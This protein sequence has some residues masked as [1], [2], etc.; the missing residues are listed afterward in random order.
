LDAADAADLVFIDESVSSSRADA[1]IDTTT[2]VINNEQYAFDNWGM[3][4]VNVGHG[5]PQRPTDA[6]AD[7]DAGSS[8][9]T[10]IELVDAA[11]PI[12]VRAGLSGLVQ[13]YDDVGGR[14]DWGRPGLE[15]DVVAQLPGFEDYQ[16]ASPI[17][18]YEAGSRLD[19]G[20][21][22]PGM[23][24]GFFISDTNRGPEPEDPDLPD[25]SADNSWDGNEA[26][27]LTEAGIALFNATVDY[28]LGISANA[29]GDYN[30]DGMLDAED[31]DLQAAEM[32]KDLA[33]QD[34]LTFDHNSDGV[35]NVGM[36]GSDTSRWGDRL[37]WIRNLRQTSVGDSNLD[38]VFDSGDLVQAFTGEKYGTGE[39]AGWE[40]GDWNGDMVF[41]SGDLVF[42]FTDGGYVSGATP[43]AVPEP[44][45]LVLL[46]FG[47]FALVH[48]IRRR[49]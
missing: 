42:A 5:S 32:K 37:I 11:H 19:D 31:I 44:A 39:M 24:I 34:L 27:L 29:P 22:A 20:S 2:P 49:E 38:G 13:V 30:G 10:T 1:I 8:F 43:V 25:D 3:T 26:T 36:A 28:A 7:L 21:T 6:G 35:V 4:G 46:V 45:C 15:A 14:I 23:R 41:D 18:V 9:G 16:P 12:A 47:G 40:F 48:P 17:F 33:E